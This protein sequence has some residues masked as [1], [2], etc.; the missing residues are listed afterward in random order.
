MNQLETPVHDPRELLSATAAESTSHIVGPPCAPS[1]LAKA[2]THESPEV[3]HEDDKQ[4]QQEHDNKLDGD[5][6]GNQLGFS[7]ACE[8]MVSY[9]GFQSVGKPFSM[10]PLPFELA[11]HDD[12]IVNARSPI[13]CKPSSNA[14]SAALS[15]TCVSALAR[16]DVKSDSREPSWTIQE[17]QEYLGMLELLQDVCCSS[18]GGEMCLSADNLG[19]MERLLTSLLP[20]GV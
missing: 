3:N 2:M 12:D 7:D 8:P 20:Q 16:N 10:A 11:D 9:D 4:M 18:K 14:R 17:F 5:Y 13:I 15:P 1:V 19:Q 6:S